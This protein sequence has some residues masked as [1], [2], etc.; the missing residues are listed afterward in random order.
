[1]TRRPGL[2]PGGSLQGAA[3]EDGTVGCLMAQSEA[4]PHSGEQ[5]GV[6]A[7]DIAP[8]D[9]RESDF[10]ILASRALPADGRRL[11]TEEPATALSGS[12]AERQGRSGGRIP[13]H[14]VMSLDDLNIEL[15]R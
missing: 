5:Y 4:L 14:P 9:H 12:L 11:A 10:A 6:F 15:R 13:L 7:N 2:E 3:G 1:L 8:P